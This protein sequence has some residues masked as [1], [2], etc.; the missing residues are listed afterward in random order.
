MAAY[1][2][3]GSTPGPEYLYDEKKFPSPS[4]T[5]SPRGPSYYYG[6][7]PQR[8]ATRAHFRGGSTSG[9]NPGYAS[10]RGPSFSPRYNSEGQYATVNVSVSRSRR[11]SFSAPP[12]PMR[13]RR[14]SFS[15]HPTSV[16]H[17]ESDEDEFIHLD[18]RTYVLPA[19]S[20]ARPH[21]D[22][23]TVNAGGHGTDRGYSAQSGTFF[24][25][26]SGFAPPPR[27]ESSRRPPPPAGHTRRASTSVPQ[28]PQTARPSAASA[29]KKP[30]ASGPPRAPTDADCRRHK[31]PPGYSLK[32]WDPTEE[33]I[34]LLGS[35]FDANS[36]G[37]W[38]YDWTVYHHGPGSPIGDQA[39]E[40]WL[41]LIQ[42]SGKIKRAEEMSSKVRSKENREMLEEFIQAGE[43]LTD[44]LRKLLKACEAPMLRTSIKPKKEGQLDKSAGVEFV[45]TLFGVDC[46]LDRTNRFMASVRLWN[47]RF[48]TNCEDLLNKPT[49]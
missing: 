45:D 38:I 28:R 43:R 12:R 25:R 20:R 17:G 46:E 13:E 3:Y 15:Y 48:D 2:P 33:P 11:P 34:M 16:S 41:L 44:K 23:F 24:D 49:V 32:N 8:P 18:D 36:L 14:S 5:P 9:V 31:I 35:V 1:S 40:L 10:P 39:G 21:K 30:P 47:L 26:E 29:H 27:F 4:P 19:R 7:T 37:K 6:A 42:L 22:H